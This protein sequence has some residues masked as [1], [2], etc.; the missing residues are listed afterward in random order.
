[1]D[2][3]TEELNLTLTAR[4]ARLGAAEPSVLQSLTESLGGAVV[5]MEVTG[6]ANS[7]HVQTK[8]LPVLEDSLRLLGT[9]ED[10]K[11]GK[12]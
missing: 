1:M 10:N 11:K 3:P 8:A 4:G 12:K 5:R 7:P 2:L 6:T 9:P